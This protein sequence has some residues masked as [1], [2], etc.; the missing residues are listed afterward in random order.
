MSFSFVAVRA[1]NILYYEKLYL[2]DQLCE[3]CNEKYVSEGLLRGSL[4]LVL[5]LTMYLTN[6]HFVITVHCD[7][8][9]PIRR[10]LRENAILYSV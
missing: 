6:S 5:G 3:N 2:L 7:Y 8:E 4:Y 9:K 10:S 1:C